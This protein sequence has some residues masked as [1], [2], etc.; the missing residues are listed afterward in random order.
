VREDEV[1]PEKWKKYM[2]LATFGLTTEE[3]LQ[4]SIVRFRWRDRHNLIDEIASLLPADGPAALVVVKLVPLNIG[5]QLPNFRVR[6]KHDLKQLGTFLDG[7]SAFRFVE[8]WYCK[9]DVDAAV[10]SVAGRIRIAEGT[11]VL[12]QVWRCSPRMIEDW[13]KA[14]LWPY[15]RATRRGWGRRWRFAE[16][17]LPERASLSKFDQHREFEHSL[18]LL[19]AYRERLEQFSDAIENCGLTAYSFEYKVVRERLSIIDWDT[20]ND[21]K[22]L[23]AYTR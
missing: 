17:Y 22:V 9:T 11:H 5:R 2:L 18:R 23:N 4:S 10:F 8:A 19:E 6:H 1:A 14:F 13:G 16:L 20:A 3:E 15:A 7:H 12:E 21:R